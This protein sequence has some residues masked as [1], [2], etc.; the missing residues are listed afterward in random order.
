[1]NKHST[2]KEI[3]RRGDRRVGTRV[4]AKEGNFRNREPRKKKP[5]AVDRASPGLSTKSDV[6][7]IARV[8]I[9][10][11][12]ERRHH[13][14]PVRLEKSPGKIVTRVAG[15]EKNANNAS[16]SRILSATHGTSPRSRETTTALGWPSSNDPKGGVHGNVPPSKSWEN[17]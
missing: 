11:E 15:E 7:I 14:S 1:M 2:Q 10:E 5:A 4:S 12:K 17:D 3:L 13:R 9:R 8:N 6:M 16:G